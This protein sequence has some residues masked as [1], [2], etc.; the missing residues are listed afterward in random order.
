MGL[1]MGLNRRRIETFTHNGEQENT[2][3]RESA[4]KYKAHLERRVK[5]SKELGEVLY[6]LP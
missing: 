4:E 2:E 3:R 6:R 1:G 5:I